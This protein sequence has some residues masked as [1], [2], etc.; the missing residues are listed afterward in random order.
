MLHQM[1]HHSKVKKTP[2]R[3]IQCVHSDIL[4]IKYP[5]NYI[6]FPPSYTIIHSIIPILFGFPVGKS[7]PPCRRT[8]SRVPPSVASALSRDA[9]SFSVTVVT[10]SSSR[11]HLQRFDPSGESWGVRQNVGKKTWLNMV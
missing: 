2:V 5:T 3:I 11:R 9:C 8:A 10:V 1:S 6:M 7:R 4:S